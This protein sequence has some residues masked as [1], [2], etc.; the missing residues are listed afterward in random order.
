MDKLS[1]KILKFMRTHGEGTDFVCP[2]DDDWGFQYEHMCTF[3]ELVQAIQ[4]SESNILSAIKWLG[5]NGW[6][7][8]ETISGN[9]REIPVAFRLSHKGMHKEE[10]TWAEAKKYVM[11]KWIDFLALLVAFIALIRTF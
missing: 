2:I 3:K 10:M 11:E 5:D 6:V 9:D 8:F 7:E 1:R 4:D